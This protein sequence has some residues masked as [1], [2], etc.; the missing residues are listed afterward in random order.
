MSISKQSIAELIAP[1]LKDMGIEL[2]ELELSSSRKPLLRLYVDRIGETQPLCTLKV[3]DCEN[4][5]RA[6]QRF[7]EVE[8][9][10]P[11]DYT[12]EVST[13]GLERPLYRASDYARFKGKLANVVIAEPTGGSFVGRIQE[14]NGDKIVFDVDGKTKELLMSQIKRAKLKFE[15]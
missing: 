9:I 14:V 12:L 2:V 8:G 13:P 6:I 10:I 15:R 3:A 11:G 4:V 5:S 1:E 7:I